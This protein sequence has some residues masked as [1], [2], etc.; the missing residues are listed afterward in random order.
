MSGSEEE[1]FDDDELEEEADDGAGLFGDD[2][3]A[4]AAKSDQQ[5]LLSDEEDLRSDRDRERERYQG[6][7]DAEEEVHEQLVSTL[8]FYRHRIPKPKDGN[9]SSTTRYFPLLFAP[10]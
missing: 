8:T 9:V 6:N 3:D 10:R 5:E 7:D 2:E 4:E 1:R